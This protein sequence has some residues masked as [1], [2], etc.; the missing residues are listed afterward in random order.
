MPLKEKLTSVFLVSSIRR[1]ALHKY[2]PP[3]LLNASTAGVGE[4]AEYQTPCKPTN[5]SKQNNEDSPISVMSEHSRRD[6]NEEFE[7]SLSR[8]LLVTG[9]SGWGDDSSDDDDDLL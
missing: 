2:D 9:A 4:T 7:A 6:L 5:P 8:P 3:E 1:V